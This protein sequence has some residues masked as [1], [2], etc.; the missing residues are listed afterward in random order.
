MVHQVH[1]I[2]GR[3]KDEVDLFHLVA[4]CLEGCGVVHSQVGEHLAVDFDAG[5]VDETHELRVREILHAG[6]CV[7]TLNPEGAEVALFLLAVAIG[8]CQTL[9]PCVF[10]NG[11]YVATASVVATGEFED[12]LS[13][14]A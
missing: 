13:L 9:F 2:V 7:D 1:H 11:P 14:G 4:D 6:G 12:F 3:I 10:G 5:L 8:V